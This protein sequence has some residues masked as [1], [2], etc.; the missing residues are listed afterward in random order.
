MFRAGSGLHGPF[1]VNGSDV[2]PPP[3]ATREERDSLAGDCSRRPRSS[4]SQGPAEEAQRSASCIGQRA[5]WSPRRPRRPG[6][7]RETALDGAP[8][9]SASPSPPAN[10]AASSPLSSDPGTP[11]PETERLRAKRKAFLCR[12]FLAFVSAPERTRTS[13]NHRFTRPSTSPGGWQMRPGPRKCWLF[14]LRGGRIGRIWLGVCSHDVLTAPSP[15]REGR[16]ARWAGRDIRSSQ[17][18]RA[19]APARR[20]RAGE[21]ADGAVGHDGRRRGCSPKRRR[22]SAGWSRSR[23]SPASTYCAPTRP[24][25]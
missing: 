21:G 6:R 3:A 22:S 1:E 24:A 13:T 19:L 15:G 18:H 11:G 2:G 7:G 25:R 14:V 20:G 17:R 5:G 10:T 12:A 8:A 16:R 23:N 9:T 4:P